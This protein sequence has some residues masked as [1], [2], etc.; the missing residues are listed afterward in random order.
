MH[1]HMAMLWRANAVDRLDIMNK[2][3]WRW[4]VVNR[5]RHDDNRFQR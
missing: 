5:V 1:M 2:L 3:G 4:A